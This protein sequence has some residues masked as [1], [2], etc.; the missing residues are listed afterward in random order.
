MYTYYLA[1][2]GL[3]SGAPFRV[4]STAVGV[5]PEFV[6]IHTYTYV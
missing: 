2:K 1:Y 6:Y 3:Y 4:A 5:H